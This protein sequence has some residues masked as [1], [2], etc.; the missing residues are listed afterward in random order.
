[1]DKEK[2]Y[3]EYHG[4]VYGYILSKVNNPQDAEDITS[5][6]F[7]KV[8]NKLDTFD[9]EKASLSTWI[10]TIARNKLTDFYRTRKVFEEV[11][12]NETDAASVEDE[13]C[14]AETLETLADALETL[15]ER[16][17]DIILL[18]FYSGKTLK[19]IAL[20]MG[21]SYAYVKILQNKA[22]DKLKKYFEKH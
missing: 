1:M 18:R 20:Q 17:R 5:E 11:S 3:Q 4:R 14:D 22:L 8:Y 6:V 21:I 13:V 12:E 9:E 2:I 16:E 7:L 10:Y 15:D 19:D